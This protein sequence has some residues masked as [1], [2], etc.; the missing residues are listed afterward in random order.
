VNLALSLANHLATRHIQEI[1]WR[2]DEQSQSG[3]LGFPERANTSAVG[4]VQWEGGGRLANSS[5]AFLRLGGR[6]KRCR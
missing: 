6:A 2:L 1:Q 5:D 4:I 3:N